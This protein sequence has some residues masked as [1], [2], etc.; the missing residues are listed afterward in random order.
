MRGI[1]AAGAIKAVGDALPPALLRRLLTFPPAAL[2][3]VAENEIEDCSD[4]PVS[5]PVMKEAD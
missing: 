4:R 3:E 5:V 2:L 1:P